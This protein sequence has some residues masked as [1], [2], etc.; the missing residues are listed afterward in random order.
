M[1][2]KSND[3]L[4]TS[5]VRPTDRPFAHCRY[6]DWRLD[7]H[8][9]TRYMQKTEGVA[10]PGERRPATNAPQPGRSLFFYP[11]DRSK[12]RGGSTDDQL[13][14]RR[15]SDEGLRHLT[16]CSDSAHL[17]AFWQIKGPVMAQFGANLHV[18]CDAVDARAE[19]G[20]A[21]QMS[22]IE[23]RRI[24]SSANV[25]ICRSIAFGDAVFFFFRAYHS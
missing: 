18:C 4:L 9:V 25:V 24:R 12:T 7:S 16:L 17:G 23:T 6:V 20:L 8:R 3:I 5:D 22:T 14:P 15:H 11:L 19:S 21:S 1:T 13:T 10:D 2:I